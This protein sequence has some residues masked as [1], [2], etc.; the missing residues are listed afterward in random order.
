MEDERLRDLNILLGIFLLES[1]VFPLSFFGRIERLG[2]A[3]RR[4]IANH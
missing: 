3:T 1:P 4:Y 2:E